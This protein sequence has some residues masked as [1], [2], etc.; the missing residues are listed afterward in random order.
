[1]NVVFSL[2]SFAFIRGFHARHKGKPNCVQ[3]IV[4]HALIKVNRPLRNATLRYTSK[5]KDKVSTREAECEGPEDSLHL[6]D[7]RFKSLW[8]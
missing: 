3:T 1:M 7:S 8:K 2:Y 6:I 5:N 4:N